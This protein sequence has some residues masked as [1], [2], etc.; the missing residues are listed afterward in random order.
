MLAALRTAGK[1][2]APLWLAAAGT[3][4]FL[5]SVWGGLGMDD[6]LQRAAL[7]GSSGL[8]PLLSSEGGMFAFAGFDGEAHTLQSVMVGF[9]PWWTSPSVQLNFWRPLSELTHKVDYRLFPEEPILM[10]LHSLLWYFLLLCAA[11]LLYRRIHA[12]RAVAGLCALLFVLDDSHTFGAS[13]IANRNSVISAVFVTLTIYFHDRSRRNECQLSA[14][15]A[16]LLAVPGLLSG[17]AYVAV[18]GYLFAHAVTLDRGPVLERVRYLVPYLAVVLGWHAVY[19]SL[20]YGSRGSAFYLDPGREP[21]LFAARLLPRL[22]LLLGSHFGFGMP[23]AAAWLNDGAG[24]AIAIGHLLLLSFVIWLVWPVIQRSRTAQ[25]WALGALLATMPFCATLPMERNLLIPG[26]GGMGLLGRFLADYAKLGVGQRPAR[27]V[28]VCVAVALIQHLV[29]SPLSKPAKAVALHWAFDRIDHCG[30]PL[31]TVPNLSRRFAVALNASDGCIAYTRLVAHQSGAEMPL[32]LRTLSNGYRS[33]V[34]ERIDDRTLR[35]KPEG[36]FFAVPLA[37]LFVDPLAPLQTGQRIQLP[38]LSI[39]IVDVNHHGRPAAIDVHFHH[40][41]DDQHYLLLKSS[42]DG[43]LQ[44]IDPPQGRL[45]LP[46]TV[47]LSPLLASSPPQHSYR[48]QQ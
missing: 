16:W 36:G 38:E 43:A 19:A 24:K 3:I 29:L 21:L 22:S 26:L 47:P 8:Q 10:H 32:T 1:P 2:R 14:V 37:R 12:S 11:G 4:L 30:E 33:T 7:T 20:G 39:T 45:V 35:V 27:L 15:G 17:E 18:L 46:P 28:H 34:V 25:F 5:P 6:H 42:P 31:K 13:W 48:A 44:P 40:P 41:L 23:E 9:L